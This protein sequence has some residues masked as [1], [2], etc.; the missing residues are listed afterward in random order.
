[1]TPSRSIRSTGLTLGLGLLVSVISVWLL[2]RDVNV[3]QLGQSLAAARHGWIIVAAV[4]IGVTFLT[5]A[6]RLTVLLQPV[7]YPGS[8]LMSTLLVGQVLNFLL[9]ARAG[10]VF[11]AVV[12]GRARGSSIERVV[13]SIAVEKTWDWVVLTLLV[14]VVALLG[15][16]PDWFVV[17]ARAFGLMAVLLLAALWFALAQRERGLALIDGLLF[18]LPARLRASVL[19]RLERAIDGMGSLRRRDAVLA[20]ALWSALTWLLG[21][22]ANVSVMAAFGVHSWPA[23][24]FLMAVLMVGVALPP[25]IAAI[26]V[27]EASTVLALGV[28]GVSAE[29]ALAIGITLHLIVFAMPAFFG[30]LLAVWESHAGRPLRRGKIQRNVD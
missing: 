30:V 4:A 9:P 19:L 27:F 12:L 2:A 11:R 14:L 25:S 20:V 10:D 16:L 26:G 23:A 17:P 18:W 3:Q 13:G 24:M 21:V 7:R 1:M 8:T 29:I 28:F 5:R 22:V 15:P 6:W